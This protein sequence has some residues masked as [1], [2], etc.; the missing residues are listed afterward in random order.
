MHAMIPQLASR[1]EAQA[2]E[3]RR[4]K[5]HALRCQCWIEGDALT[6]FGSTIDVGVGGLFLRTAVPVEQGSL[7]DLTLTID[8]EPSALAARAL[9]ARAVRAKNGARHGLGL[10]FV[11]I[12]SGEHALTSLLS[13]SVSLAWL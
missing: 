13:R 8:R 7:V 5:R 1:E 6:V 4:Y 2:P 12:S 3:R 9:V 11:E 10:E